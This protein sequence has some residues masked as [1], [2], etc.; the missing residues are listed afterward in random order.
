MPFANLDSP[1]VFTSGNDCFAVL[2]LNVEAF[3]VGHS[4]C[5]ETNRGWGTI[6]AIDHVT[7]F[8]I[9]VLLKSVWS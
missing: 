5:Y 6:V 9:A 4:L 2:K 3:F 7:N 1:K 8:E